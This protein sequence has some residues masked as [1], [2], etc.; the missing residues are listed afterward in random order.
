MTDDILTAQKRHLARLLE[1]IQRCAYFLYQ[2]E[3]RIQWPLAGETLTT[4]KKDVDLF[5]TLAAI[6]ERFAKL[7]DSL[8]TAM[9]HC[10]YLAGEPSDNF[11]KVLG[12]FEK[13]A[14][15]T[16][17]EDWQRCRAARNLAAHDYDTDYLETA[18]HFNTLHQL[19]GILYATSERFLAFC[20]TQL[21][22]LPIS[23]DFSQEF[24]SIT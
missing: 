3:Q 23:D 18:E 15:I 21:G 2:S 5:E 7:Q 11:L 4:R 17:R 19:S 10:A 8:A 14:V 12:F 6:N 24:Q 20:E 13:E 1:A 16:S 22:V 9:R